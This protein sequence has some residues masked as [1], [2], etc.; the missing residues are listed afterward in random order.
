M[1][2]LI[3]S[4]RI[5]FVTIA[6]AAVVA[7]SS[8]ALLGRA[9][10]RRAMTIEDLLTAV[11]VADASLSPDGQSVAYVR[12]TTNLTTGRRN[13]DIY[14][15]PA[16]GSASGKLLAGSDQAEEA[17][18]FSADSRSV[19]FIS[20]RGGT[21]QVYIVGVGG[22]DPRLVTRVSTGAQAPLVVSPDGRYVAF[23]SDVFP[24]CRDD[25][26]NKS[27]GEALEKD[28]VKVRR[29]T[30]LMFRHWDEWR[31]TRR[32]HVF[33]AELVTGETR[34]VRPVDCD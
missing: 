12:T 11:R 14:I 5:P 3:R 31:D 6:V 30:E 15:A 23:V 34:D 8:L 4:A 21:P 20:A 16:D 32:H 18:Q 9:Q 27:R 28:P 33:V 22:G 19:A 29:L 13:G 17:P 7:G 10:A 26:C 1:N 25:G 24:D 2:H